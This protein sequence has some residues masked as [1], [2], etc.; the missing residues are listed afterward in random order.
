MQNTWQGELS[1]S[2]KPIHTDNEISLSKF[3]NTLDKYAKPFI[4][5]RGLRCK[6]L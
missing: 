5:Y 4:D 6:P 2:G 1:H 3:S